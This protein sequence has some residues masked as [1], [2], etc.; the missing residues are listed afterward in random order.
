MLSAIQGR[1]TQSSGCAAPLPPTL[2]RPPPT[3]S[4]RCRQR[5]RREALHEL[6][7]GSLSTIRRLRLQ[8]NKDE[9]GINHH[10]TCGC[11]HTVKHIYVRVTLWS[12][13]VL[14]NQRLTAAVTAICPSGGE[15]GGGGGA[16]SVL[17]VLRLRRDP[18]NSGIKNSGCVSKKKIKTVS[19]KH[20]P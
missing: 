8:T 15:L 20:E 18:L 2:V 19:I 16:E 14:Y 9:E 1:G 4:K 7:A 11:V 6:Q 3:T 12:E 13:T 17:N 5:K 10:V